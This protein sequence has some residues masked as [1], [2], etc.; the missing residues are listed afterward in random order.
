MLAPAELRMLE[1]L[2]DANRRW[3]AEFPL[4]SASRRPAKGLAVLTCMDARVDPLAIFGLLP[5][6]AIILRNAGGRVTED[7]VRSLLL[8]SSLLGVDSIVVLHHTGC[9]LA[10]TT[11]AE[12]APTLRSRAAKTDQPLLA[13]PQPDVALAD[14]V[15][16][17]RE[18][19]TLPS[20]LVV[21]G[22]RYDVAT[23]FVEEIIG[24]Q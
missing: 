18:C 21:V 24:Q 12:L 5:G 20:E 23:G 16:G 15:A 13:M 8:A 10:G 17:L 4:S 11:D 9:A 7:V 3:A 22:W 14:D 19:E 1:S 6:D 2:R